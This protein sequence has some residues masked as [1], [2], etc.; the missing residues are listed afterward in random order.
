MGGTNFGN[1]I[2]TVDFFAPAD[3]AVV[4]R[5]FKDTRPLGIYDGGYLTVVND[6]T[7][8][9]GASVSIVGDGSHQIRVETQDAQNLTVSTTLEWVVFRWAYNGAA[10]NYMDMLALEEADI[11]D[12]DIIVGL[13]NFTGSTLTG[14]DYT[15]RTRP[16]TLE[17]VFEVEP[18]SPTSMRV[19]V[20]GGNINFGTETFT[21]VDQLSAVFTAPSTNPRIDLVTISSAGTVVVVTG[22]QA[23]SPV[24]PD[25]EGRSVLA[26]I[27]LTTSTTE[28]TMDEIKDVRSLYGN[29]S[30]SFRFLADTPSSY[31]GEAG[32]VPKVNTGETALEFGF[33]NFSELGDGPGSLAGHGG[34]T[35]MVNTGG[36]ALE[37]NYGTF[38]LLSDSPANYAGAANQFVT[39][40]SAGT[41]VEFSDSSIT[42]LGDVPNTFTGSQL[43]Y[44]RVNAAQTAIQ[45]VNPTLVELA[46]TPSSYSGQASRYLRVNSGETVVEFTNQLILE[47]RSSDPSSPAT[48]R[49]WLRTDIP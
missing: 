9:I 10:G 38:L 26:E 24:A 20:K 46:D 13:C 25:Y 4:N 49:M 2:I 14:F 30:A 7:V 8:T 45:F 29:S 40:N 48:G 37:F 3:S 17:K 43:K 32:K 34:K 19:R 44:L 31:S 1:Q 28:I 6:T 12:Y 18:T 35:V 36:T 23:A 41:A 21:V 5:G 42:R 15:N 27:S 47:N 22:T 16:V 11:Q 39:V 33:V